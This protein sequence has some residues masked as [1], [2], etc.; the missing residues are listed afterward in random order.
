MKL[1]PD[2]QLISSA[3]L[4]SPLLAFLISI[5]L[6]RL[7]IEPST[8]F[9]IFFTKLFSPATHSPWP[10][11]YE[12]VIF[13]I[14]VPRI[15]AALL[16][17]VALSVS[18]A[19][20]QAVFRNP[21]VDTYV[22]GV[23]AGSAFGAALAI[24]L[25]PP[26]TGITESLAFL[27][28]VTAFA[29]TYLMAK[30]RSG[31][32]IVSL[33]LAGIIVSALFSAGLSIIKFIA[34]PNRI[35][36]VV[37]WLMG[38]FSTITWKNVWCML[39]PILIGSLILYLMR[40]RLNVLSMKEEEAKSL[41]VNVERDRLIVLGAATL[42]TSS[43][44]SICGI[45]GWIGLIVPHTIRMLFNTADNRVVLP[46]S[47]TAGATILLLADDLARTLTPYE[48]PVGVLTTICGA[49]FFL[50]LLKARGGG[51]WR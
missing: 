16:G 37:Y 48:I 24:V 45:I 9:W 30:T 41:G 35:A 17:G 29:L 44:V 21:L 12:V 32:P 8:V 5:L 4:V 18:G 6:G 47:A 11:A 43:L 33:I 3:I 28:G 22:L 38:R 36:D 20:L 31:V 10:A 42:V 27:F 19:S 7:P 34:D 15:L 14:R 13:Q 2:K 23:S 1:P 49:P 51:M 25:L 40:W 39:P 46:L 50:Y 26:I